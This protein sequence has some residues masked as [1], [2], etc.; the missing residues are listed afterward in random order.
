MI[1]K[2]INPILIV[3]MYSSTR[4]IVDFSTRQH[5]WVLSSVL[6]SIY[7]STEQTVATLLYSFTKKMWLLYSTRVP[8]FVDTLP[9][10]SLNPSL[11]PHLPNLSSP[12]E[13]NA[14]TSVKH[15]VIVDMEKR[16][17]YMYTVYG[18]KNFTT[19]QKIKNAFL[20]IRTSKSGPEAQLFQR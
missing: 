17:G 2:K 14:R 19:Q 15:S 1:K 5:S 9:N 18:K 11:L 10:T 3:N 13:R 8:H 20:Y 6:Y 16:S 7:L 4:L 12:T